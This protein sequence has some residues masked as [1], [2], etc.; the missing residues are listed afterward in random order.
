MANNPL[1]QFFRQPK[2]YISLPS[3]GVYNK[4][5]AIAGDPEKLA[6]FGMTGMDEILLKTP[7]ALLSGESTVKV[8]HSCIPGI[9]DPWDLS[10]LDTDLI[11]AAIRIATYGKDLNISHI[12]PTCST[13][14]E[15]TLDLGQMIDHFTSCKY[16][17]RLVLKDLS[18]TTRPLTYKQST[19][20]SLQN[21]QYQQRLKNIDNLTDEAEKK[22]L[23][24]EVFTA[25]ASLRTAVYS[26][27]IE[28]ITVNNQKVV[29]REFINEFLENCDKAVID[30]IA[31]H[32]DRNQDIWAV[33][34]QKV[35]CENC[36]AE[37][38]VSVNLDQSNFFG[39][40]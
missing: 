32:I 36:N 3:H 35:H 7:D 13:E 9:E 19:E 38:S 20:F 27:G 1:Q 23:M 2:I 26:A 21:F 33:P 18:I 29:E 37:N 24:T 12:C 10:N 16:D 30:S 17:N 25:L 5:G 8:I 11:L 31:K 22:N 28:S 39:N 34:E 14:N 6:V 15:Y 40:A 4:P